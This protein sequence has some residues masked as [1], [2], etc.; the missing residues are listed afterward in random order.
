MASHKFSVVLLMAG[1]LGSSVA[2]AAAPGDDSAVGGSGAGGGHESKRIVSRGLGFIDGRLT[3][4]SQAR[5]VAAHQ[6]LADDNTA[7]LRQLE[8]YER[9]VARS[10]G[11]SYAGPA[12]S[13]LSAESAMPPLV[14]ADATGVAADKGKSAAKP[15]PFILKV[16]AIDQK[17]PRARYVAAAGLAAIAYTEATGRTHVASGIAS[18]AKGAAASVG[19]AFSTLSAGGE[20]AH[21]RTTPAGV[22]R[23]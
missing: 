5:L 12:S 1:L 4:D 15:S 14:P 13:K 10:S 17:Y 16:K 18:A 2:F 7:M 3:P 11:Q 23:R 22:S 20:R 21:V 19:S 6:R 9:I 8:D